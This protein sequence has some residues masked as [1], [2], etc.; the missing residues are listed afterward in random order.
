MLGPQRR[1][2]GFLR[3]RGAAEAA[4]QWQ[5]ILGRPENSPGKSNALQNST[6]MLRALMLCEVC[7]VNRQH[8]CVSDVTFNNRVFIYTKL[9]YGLRN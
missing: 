6:A 8:T 7:T 2:L 3:G 5:G 4:R 9:L 1:C